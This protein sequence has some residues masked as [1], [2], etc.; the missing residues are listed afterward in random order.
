[1]IPAKTTMSQIATRQGVAI[2]GSGILDFVVAH[3]LAGAAGIILFEAGDLFGGHT[4]TVNATLPCS[5]K[6]NK[7][8][9]YGDDT[10][11]LVFNE[12]TYSQSIQQFAELDLVTAKLYMS[13]SVKVP[14]SNPAQL[15][16]TK[17]LFAYESS[18]WLNARRPLSRPTPAWCSVC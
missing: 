7:L 11:F 13:F 4:H 3:R 16:L 12:H 15:D 1:M 14:A 6:P 5:K 9:I 10:C 2:I 17:D 18:I 8:A